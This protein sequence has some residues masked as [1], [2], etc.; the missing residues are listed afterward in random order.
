MSEKKS[1]EQIAGHLAQL[2]GWELKAQGKQS[3]ICRTFKF[4][5]FTAAFSFM[6]AVAIEAE[7]MNHHP[8]WSNVY[9]TVEIALTTHD[10]GGLTEKDFTLAERIDRRAR[11]LGTDDHG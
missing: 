6:A 10:A 2:N 4:A 11:A 7:K 3:K 9:A 5:D 8:E 1:A